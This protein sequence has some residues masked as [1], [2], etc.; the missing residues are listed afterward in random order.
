PGYKGRKP[1]RFDEELKKINN[2]YFM[3][4]KRYRKDQSF[5]EKEFITKF[6]S[7]FRIYLAYLKDKYPSM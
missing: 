6:K 4:Y 5:F 1:G 7:D 3:D 2:T